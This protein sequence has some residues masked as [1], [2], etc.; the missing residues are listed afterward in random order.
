LWC[1][2]LPVLSGI[3]GSL[4]EG[5]ES[6]RP[7]IALSLS[8]DE[9]GKHLWCLVLPVLSG[10]EGSRAECTRTERGDRVECIDKLNNI[11]YNMN[12]DSERK[13]IKVFSFSF[14]NKIKLDEVLKSRPKNQQVMTLVTSRQ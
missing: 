6:L 12:C 14:I 9:G 10:I 4:V 1:L 8:K 3:E 2:V 13:Y 11:L 5:S 7:S